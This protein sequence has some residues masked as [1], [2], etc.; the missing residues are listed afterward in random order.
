MATT[1]DTID[2]IVDIDDKLIVLLLHPTL[3]IH[4]PST[5]QEHL[6]HLHFDLPITPLLVASADSNIAPSLTPEW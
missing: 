5:Q 2:P 1:T 4:L 6:T 3:L